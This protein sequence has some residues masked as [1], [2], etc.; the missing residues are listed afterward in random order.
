MSSD[1]PPDQN[2]SPEPDSI[3]Q[4]AINR[5][6]DPNP[7][8]AAPSVEF[9]TD[10]ELAPPPVAV[11][12]EPTFTVNDLETA[13]NDEDVNSDASAEELAETIR[14]WHGILVYVGKKKTALAWRIGKALTL[15]REKIADGKW[16][17]Y[18]SRE[19]PGVS[20]TTI[21]RYIQL[22]QRARRKPPARP[23]TDAYSAL[24][25]VQPARNSVDEYLHQLEILAADIWKLERTI[26]SLNNR[27]TYLLN[28]IEDHDFVDADGKRL[29]EHEAGINFAI[30]NLAAAADINPEDNL[31]SR[32]G[33]LISADA[34][35]AVLNYI[36]KGLR[37]PF[38]AHHS[39]IITSDCIPEVLLDAD[40]AQRW[41]DEHRAEVERNSRNEHR[42][43][44]NYA[45]ER[46]RQGREDSS[47]W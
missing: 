3:I 35:L 39:D 26:R 14:R 46:M 6:N 15:A 18:L 2:S 40:V 32:H 33:D 30:K 20:K 34:R 10:P 41:E 9:A 47:Y 1:N 36:G 12:D 42:R 19:F 43:K 8:P 16:Y 44:T 22:Y 23:L 7:P 25:I 45:M 17:D 21:W 38:A 29:I 4:D 37:T 5:R 31:F 24:G 11:K 27:R 28:M 13:V